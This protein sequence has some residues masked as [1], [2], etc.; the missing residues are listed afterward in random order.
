MN[1]KLLWLLVC[2]ALSGCGSSVTPIVGCNESVRLRVDC[3]F[4]NPED[5]AALPSGRGLLVSQLGRVDG[6]QPG[7]LV[8]YPRP[9]GAIEVLFPTA[10]VEDDRSWGAADCPPPDLAAFYP[11]GIDLQQRADGRWMLLV[12]NHGL[13][14]SVEFL[15]L[16]E[17][18]GGPSLVWRG[19]VQGP[20]QALFNDVVARSDGGFWV[21]HMMPYDS[22]TSAMVRAALFGS[23]VG[24]VYAWDPLS[25]FSEVAGSRGP[26]P[27]G[28]E[29]SADERYL[30]VNVYFG[31]EVRKLDLDQGQV[32]GRAA[33][34]SPDNSSWSHTGE[35]LVASHN[36]TLTEMMACQNLETGSCG[37]R[38]Q[39]VAIDPADMSSRVVFDN[40]EGGY[41]MGGATVAVEFAGQVYLGTH[42]GNRIGRTTLRY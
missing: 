41:P 27:N 4:D 24:F 30:F 5:L 28:I 36:A 31:D 17:D 39:I 37:H 1:S 13:R 26:F 16:R 35:L 20:D 2:L 22:Q 11:H 38:F 23:D 34:P 25:G 33:I 32:V 12:V 10:A 40:G 7:S 6:T 3:R 15:E 9:E 19:C 21:T 8:F 42:A 29:K 14:E 18:Q